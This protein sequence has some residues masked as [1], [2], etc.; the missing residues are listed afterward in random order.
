VDVSVGCSSS[1]IK[2]KQFEN[3]TIHQSALP[4]CSED[5]GKVPLRKWR[6][7]WKVLRGG[8]FSVSQ[9]FRVF[10]SRHPILHQPRTIA[11]D[12]TRSRPTRSKASR[13][14]HLAASVARPHPQYCRASHQPVS[15]SLQGI[16]PV[17]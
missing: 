4:R 7:A 15:A 5:V 2:H 9:R 16:A 14:G 17:M 11:T 13:S 10:R 6:A 1:G 3:H 8:N 12:T